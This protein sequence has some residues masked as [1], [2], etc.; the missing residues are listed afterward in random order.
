[1]KCGGSLPRMLT[2]LA[3]ASHKPQALLQQQQQQQH[4]QVQHLHS[5]G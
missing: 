3:L 2:P 4:T 1:V 5:P